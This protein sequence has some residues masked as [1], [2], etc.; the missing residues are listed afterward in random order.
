VAAFARRLVKEQ[1]AGK[2]ITPVIDKMNDLAQQYYDQSRPVYC[3][4]R[5][6]VDEIVPFSAMRE[7]AVGFVR[8]A[9]QAPK[10][11]CPHHQMLLPRTIR[12]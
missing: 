6:F 4:Q 2:D 8:A 9:H 5:G 3:A 7:Y 12:G 10:S 11:I 1:D